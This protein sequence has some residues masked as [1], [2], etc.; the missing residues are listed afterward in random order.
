MNMQEKLDLL[1]TRLAE[2]S[3]LRGIQA[4]MGWDQQVNM[5]RGGAEARSQQMATLA[6]IS[7]L[8][9]TDPEIG[10][11]IND[12]IP[13]ADQLPH[14]SDEARLIKVVKK[15]YDKRSKV[16]SQFVAEFAQ[17]SAIAQS[18]WEKARELDDFSMF[19]PHLEKII[20]LRRQYAGYFAPFDHIYDPLL[21]D[22]EPGMKTADI[23]TIFNY[24]RPRQVEL[25]NA[26]SGKPEV[27]DSFLYLDYPEKEQRVFG[28]EVITR[29]GYDWNCGRL[30]TSAHP[31][32]TSFSIGDVRITTRFLTNHPASALFGTMHEAGHGMYNQGIHRRF[33]RT[34]LANGASL[35]IHESQ[36]RLWENLVG[37]SRPF[38]T[39]FYPRLQELFPTQLNNVSIEYFYRAINKVKPSL[40]RVEADEATY[41]LHIMLRLEIEIELME[42]N[43]QVK[44]LPSV[45]TE[46]MKAYLGV[47]PPN[48]SLGVMQDIHWSHGMIGYFPTYSL[49]NLVSVQLWEVIRND[50][51]NLDDQISK[52]EFSSLLNWLHQKIHTHGSKFE[53]QELVEMV[54][55]SKIS[56]DAY[57]RYLK[58]KYADIYQL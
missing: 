6:R 35:A 4:L 49:G 24:L 48:N 31:F 51:S 21:D 19:Q 39:F 2:V 33:E 57:L 13:F 16:P 43:L 40:I 36:S 34:P 46:R 23:Q 56:A 45:W 11:L 8:K 29:F 55:G 5:P 32:T 58:T 1:K 14:D 12:L 53:P 47:T 38:W 20:Q 44:D 17:A 52:G 27:D 54:T 41:N 25:V 3:D 26:I 9:F 10:Q 7:H 28:N 30:D 37:R 15:R 50:I 18:V 42:G 22:F